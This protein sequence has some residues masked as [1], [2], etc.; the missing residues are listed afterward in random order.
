M[1][2]IFGTHHPT[3]GQTGFFIGIPGLLSDKP[4]QNPRTEK[5]MA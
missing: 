3:N 4:Q 1:A 5:R 2:F